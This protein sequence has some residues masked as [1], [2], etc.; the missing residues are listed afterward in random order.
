ME[1]V[2][3]GVGSDAVAGSPYARGARAIM[4]LDPIANRV[5]RRFRRHVVGATGI[6]YSG[7]GNIDAMAIMRLLQPRTG[8]LYRLAFRQGDTPCT[9]PFDGVT[10]D[11]RVVE[12]RVV[13]HAAVRPDA[14]VSWGEVFLDSVGTTSM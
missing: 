4:N 2:E 6:E 8:R 1:P 7:A 5:A 11:G 9:V 14:I 10:L 3:V 12:G 13:L